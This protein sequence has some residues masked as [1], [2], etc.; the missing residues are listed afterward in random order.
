MNNYIYDEVYTV[1]CFDFFHKGHEIILEEMKKYGRKL[2]VGVHDDKSIEQLKNLKPTDHEPI[3]IRIKKVKAKADVVF[4][5]PNK[6]PTLYINMIHNQNK[7]VKQVFIR[8][9]DNFNFPGIE[10]VQKHMDI[11]YL[12]YT[13]EISSTQI[14]KKRPK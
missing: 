9:D 1:G 13:P 6:N 12:P 10:Y 3:S 5:I 14:R 7:S 11:K 2:I 8:G 4:V